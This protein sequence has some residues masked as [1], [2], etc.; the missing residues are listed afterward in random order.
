MRLS[1]LALLVAAALV[2]GCSEFGALDLQGPAAGA[3]SPQPRTY[4][5][6][7]QLASPPE[8]SASGGESSSRC[9][10]HFVEHQ[11]PHVTGTAFE[12]VHLFH[13]QRRRPRRRR[14]RQ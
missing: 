7:R 6:S 11:L 10:G 13:K 1:T 5:I 12:R 8:S 4:V 3:G 14:P 9:S 2:A